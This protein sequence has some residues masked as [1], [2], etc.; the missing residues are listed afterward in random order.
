M[1]GLQIRL[2]PNVEAIPPAEVGDDSLN[3]KVRFSQDGTEM[4]K[5]EE[6]EWAYVAPLPAHAIINLGDAMTKFSAGIL[7]SNI[8]RVISPPGAQANLTRYSLVY[9]T[10]PEYDVQLRHLGT[11]SEVIMKHLRDTGREHDAEEVYTSK[12]W[13]NKMSLGRR[14]MATWSHSGGKVMDNLRQGLKA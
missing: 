10:R 14:N 8:H 6:A 2:P 13:V 1:G 9:F 5:E 7:R 3:G 12:D 4:T 11:E